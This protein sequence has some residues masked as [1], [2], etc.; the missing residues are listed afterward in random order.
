MERVI[1]VD[2]GGT[3]THVRIERGPER[4]ADYVVPTASWWV[5]GS[6]LEHPDNA[7]TLARELCGPDDGASAVVVGAHGIDSVRVAEAMAA[8][9]RRF[10]AGP[11]RVLNDA[12]LVG[13]AAGYPGA[14]V[15]VIAGTGSIVLATDADGVEV[16]LGGHGYLLG[17]EGSAPALVRDLAR[18]ILRGVDRGTTDVIA[19]RHLLTAAGLPPS[20]EPEEDLAAELHHRHSITDWGRL[21]PAVFAAADAGSP[22]ARAVV[23]RHADEVVELVELHLARGVAPEAVVLAGGV[24]T[25][26]PRLADAIRTGVHRAHP[27]LPVVLLTQPPVEGAVVLARADLARS[28]PASRSAD[29]ATEPS[30]THAQMPAQ[31]E[32]SRP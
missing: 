7:A 21:A 22:L 8:E 19:L 2:V 29:P 14:V 6:P 31:P 4:L 1:G 12:A 5:P 28:H 10:F 30:T 11:V 3:K 23:Q 16:R 18:D 24:V 26:Q 13:P 27:G 17:D 9:L 32:G 20:A 15:T 25:A